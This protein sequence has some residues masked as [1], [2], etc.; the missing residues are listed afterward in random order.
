MRSQET[1]FYCPASTTNFTAVNSGP[2]PNGSTTPVSENVAFSIANAVTLFNS[3]NTAFNN[4]G[5]A[6]PGAFDWGLP[7]FFGRSVFIG[8]EN[9]S[10]PAGLGPYWAY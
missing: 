4:V 6:N 3:P 7:F 5:G 2:N 10:T 1:S 9:Q 8:I